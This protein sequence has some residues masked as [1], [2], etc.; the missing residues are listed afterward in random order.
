MNPVRT[1]FYGDF[2][3][4]RSAWGLLLLRLL[5]GAALMTHGFP[6][7]QH[8][9]SWMGPSAP[10]PGVF[11]FLAAFSEFFGGLAF[12]AGLLTPLAALGVMA[13]MVV[14][15]FVALGSA[16]FISAKPQ[17]PSKEPALSYF[18][19]AATLFLAGPGI[20]SLDARLFDRKRDL[21]TS[22]IAT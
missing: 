12:I 17:A 15:A 19:V 13:T 10:V 20:L 16:P 5:A 8:P 9:F 3:R 2:A 1:F 14:A 22:R 7:I 4:G 18:A 11:Q 21:D 6:K